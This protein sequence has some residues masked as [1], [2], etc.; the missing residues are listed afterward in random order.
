MLLK[1]RSGFL[2]FKLTQPVRSLK[3]FFW[4]LIY[5]WK[6]LVGCA[7]FIKFELYPQLRDDSNGG[8]RRGNETKC[9]DNKYFIL[10]KKQKMYFWSQQIDQSYVT[11]K[12]VILI[13]F[14]SFNFINRFAMTSLAGQEEGMKK[15]SCCILY[16]VCRILNQCRLTDDFNCVI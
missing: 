13:L 14:S 16:S 9:F 5:S 15:V 1:S 11:L 7:C 10:S 12:T 3:F 8:A 6:I 2:I 4:T